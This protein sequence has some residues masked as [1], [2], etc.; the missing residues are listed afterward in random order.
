MSNTDLNPNLP[1]WLSR[2][3][4]LVCD[5]FVQRLTRWPEQARRSY[6]VV[7]ARPGPG[8]NGG[9][10]ITPIND[11]IPGWEVVAGPFLGIVPTNRLRAD[12]HK[13]APSLHLTAWS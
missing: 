3:V 12:L 1:D 10:A 13:L 11:H 4:D 9:I 6:N 5:A 7:S 8:Y 2:H